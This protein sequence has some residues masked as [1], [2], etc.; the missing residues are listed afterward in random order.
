MDVVV[1]DAVE[2]ETKVLLRGELWAEPWRSVT[3]W[4]VLDGKEVGK[5]DPLAEAKVVARREMEP[6]RVPLMI[7]LVDV[8]V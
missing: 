7:V 3:E 5:E 1:L 2:L 8:S 4:D 6:L